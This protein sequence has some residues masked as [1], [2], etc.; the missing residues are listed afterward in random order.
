MPGSTYWHRPTEHRTVVILADRGH[1]GS[2][3]P[4]AHTAGGYKVYL[5]L[6]VRIII[7]GSIRKV[8]HLCPYRPVSIEVESLP[9]RQAI[10]LPV[11]LSLA[12]SRI[13]RSQRV[14]QEIGIGQV[15]EI[16]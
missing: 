16:A 7:V 3:H 4:D 1:W 11:D 13:K 12:T 5:Q 15:V 10:A 2:E 8:E 9:R 6:Q 14:S